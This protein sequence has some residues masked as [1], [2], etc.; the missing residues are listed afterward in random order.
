VVSE[1]IQPR[2]SPTRRGQLAVPS[3]PRLVSRFVPQD[4]FDGNEADELPLSCNENDS[5]TAPS[6]NQHIPI[7]VVRLTPFA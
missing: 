5:G 4:V 2:A 1:E 7:N 6:A 3:M